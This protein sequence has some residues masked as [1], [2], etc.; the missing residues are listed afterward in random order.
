MKQSRS[1][2][3]QRSEQ[4]NLTKDKNNSAVNLHV[5][6]TNY[7]TVGGHMGDKRPS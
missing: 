1:P 7:K 5:K 3:R 4:R 2:S 6:Q